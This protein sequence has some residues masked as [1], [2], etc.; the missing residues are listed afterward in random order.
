MN[1]LESGV[2]LFG[3]PP[4]SFVPSITKEIVFE[5]LKRE[6]GYLREELIM[7]PDSEWRDVPFYRRY[8]VLTLCR[9]L[10][11]FNKGTVVSKPRAARWALKYLPHEW[12]KIIIQALNP[13]AEGRTRNIPL[14]AIRRFI[15]FADAQFR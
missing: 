6:V 1:V 14:S 9:I 4:E 10:Y 15:K 11:S 12:N 2:T 7:K 13:D 3:A 5:A 8:A